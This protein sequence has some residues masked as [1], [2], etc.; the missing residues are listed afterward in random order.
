MTSDADSLSPWQLEDEPRPVGRAAIGWLA[1]VLAALYAAMVHHGIGAT[2]SAAAPAWWQPTDFMLDWEFVGAF[3]DSREA[4][5]RG[6]FVM[7]IPAALLT[8]VT[9]WGTRSSW[10]RAIGLSSI[11]STALFAFYGFT[12]RGPWEFFHWRASLV[13]LYVGLAIGFT[14]ASPLLAAAWL[15]RGAILKLVLYFPFFFAVV[16]L[17]RNATGTDEN[18]FF[19]F[20][21]WPAIPIFGLEIGAYT[22]VGILFGVSAGLAGLARGAERPLG[23]IAGLAAALIIP[24][25][26]FYDRFS[27]SESDVV[28]GIALLVVPALGLALITTGGNRRLKLQRR[29]L[30]VFLGAL[31]VAVPLFTGRAWAEGDYAVNKFVRAEVI[32]R[33]IDAYLDGENEYPDKLGQLV[34]KGYLE[35]VPSPRVGFELFYW[36]GLNQ[37][38]SFHYQDVGAG[39]VLEFVSTEWVMCSYS[40]PWDEEYE[41]EEDEEY[42]DYPE[43]DLSQG[44][45]TC[46]DTRPQLW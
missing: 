24:A 36:L 39:Y 41:D 2:S 38:N 20:S 31:L 11:V 7:S 34:E 40:P 29:A 18:L 6:I 9:F 26:W 28:V 44:G 42:E 4:S 25:V 37:Y 13:F 43:D 12:A 46:P 32:I 16:A 15:R 27:Q 45:W 10:A 14:L 3:M 5:M 35:E 1:M 23:A 19:N 22:L 8:A 30:H 33:A 21:P 17:L